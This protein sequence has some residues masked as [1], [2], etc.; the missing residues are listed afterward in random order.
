[1]QSKRVHGNSSY[2]PEVALE[3][4]ERISAG[5][6]LVS[7]CRDQSMPSYT[8][9]MGWLNRNVDDFAANYVHARE[10]QADADADAITD[11]GARALSGEIEPQAAR[12]AIEAYKWSASRRAPKK[13]GDKQTTELTG[14]NG[15]AIQTESRI[16]MSTLT[17]EQVRVLAGIKVGEK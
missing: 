12:V 9:V 6:P 11:I 1:M 3:I 5:E 2:T 10:A 8:T 4:C 14:P 7:I 17:D 13:Y 15:G 16:D